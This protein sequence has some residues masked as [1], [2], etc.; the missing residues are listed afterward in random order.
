MAWAA[1]SASVAGLGAAGDAQLQGQ[2]IWC[3]AKAAVGSPP[4]AGGVEILRVA[5][6]QVWQAIP[7]AV[8]VDGR[9][10]IGVEVRRA[11]PT[12]A[13]CAKA[14]IGCIQHLGSCCIAPLALGLRRCRE[15]PQEQA[16]GQQAPL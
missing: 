1:Y 8:E 16:K 5:K 11:R 13:Q 4:I 12:V 10:D 2:I 7:K 14:V 6:P 3:H 15:G 9:A